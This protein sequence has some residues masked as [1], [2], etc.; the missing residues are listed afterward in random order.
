VQPDGKIVVVSPVQGQTPP[1]PPFDG[2]PS[3]YADWGILR[4]N[5]DGTLDND[6]GAGGRVTTDFGWAD[7]PSAALLTPD[8]KLIVT[9]AAQ[10]PDTDS[11]FALARYILTDPHALTSR[12]HDRIL[13]ITGT[14]ADDTISIQIV[15]GRLSSPGL[16][17]T[18][19]TSTFSKIQINALA[20]N[21]T[22][23]ASASPVPVIL[24]GGDGNDLLLG[25]AYADLLLGN[26]GND[27]LFGGRGNDTLHGNDDNDYLNGGPG[28][29]QLFGDAGN[30]QLFALDGAVDAL[31]GGAGFDRAKADTADLLSGV[32]GLL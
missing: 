20:G 13:T 4:Y 6:F 21:D 18:Y 19:P 23:D 15:N 28:A 5:V 24:N 32:E 2:P 17:E 10:P 22:L 12:L 14:R 25:G 3:L 16:S 8:N 29:D 9:G 30:D 27:T 31:Y 1:A 11:D 26:A 7:Y